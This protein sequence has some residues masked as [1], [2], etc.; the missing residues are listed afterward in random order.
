M[1]ERRCPTCGALV[2]A[3]AEW[4]G[5]CYASLRAP[6]AEPVHHAPVAAATEGRVGPATEEEAGAKTPEPASAAPVPASEAEPA[7][8]CP[9]C[10]NRNPI[11]LNRCA[12]CGT[13]F[14]RLFQDAE[15]GPRVSPRGAAVWS[16][17]LPGLG[18]WKCGRALDAIVWM[19]ISLWTVGT[20]VLMFLSRTGSSGLGPTIPLLIVFLVA[21]VVL[22]VTSALDAY[23][24][25]SGVRPLVTSRALL[26][27]SVALVVLSVVL[28]ATLVV[29]P[30]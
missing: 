16:L 29:V 6:A 15:P 27:G 22:W 8:P 1:S 4:C 12:V 9:V 30:A 2:S 14:A 7:W 23:R 26:W 25:A 24:I 19:A 21:I 28:L 11:E 10:G 3:D 17:A 5:Q 18:H 13:S 20:V